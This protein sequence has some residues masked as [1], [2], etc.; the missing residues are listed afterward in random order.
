MGTASTDTKGM[1]ADVAIDSAEDRVEA[2]MRIETLLGPHALERF[3]KV[4]F[5]FADGPEALTVGQLRLLLQLEDHFDWLLR[6]DQPRLQLWRIDARRDNA[7]AFSVQIADIWQALGISLGRYVF[8]AANWAKT[9]DHETGLLPLTIAVALHCYVNEIR[10]RARGEQACDVPLQ[11]LHRLYR[12]AE[13]RNIAEKDVYPYEADVDFSITPKGQYVL[14]LLMADLSERDLPPTQRLIAQN[15]LGEWARDVV[16]DSHLAHDQHSMVVDLDSNEGIQRVT[17]RTLP[18]YRY[19]DIRAIA[20]RV[21]ETDARLANSSAEDEAVWDMPEATEADYAD[22]LAWLE[23]LYQNRSAAFQ[24]TRERKAAQPDRFARVLIGWNHIQDFIDGSRWEP[25]GSRGIFPAK[26]PGAP[27]LGAV[28][29]VL[30]RSST[31][32]P[33]F[34]A[35]QD[36]PRARHDEDN[37]ALWR[38]RDISEGGVG[39]SSDHRQDADLAVG[40]LI[41]LSMDREPNWSLGRIVRKFKG[42]EAADTRF[43][44]QILGGNAVPVR[45]TPRPADDQVK[46]TLL[47]NVTGLFL[48]RQNAAGTPDAEDLLLISSGALAYTRRY[49]LKSGN[50]RIPIRTTL[51]VQS[52]GAWAL[53]QYEDDV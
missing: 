28:G 36:V 5:G 31:D 11:A 6:N 2:I 20:R 44:I 10:W 23:K 22:T 41:L 48:T 51:P 45:L 21:E 38:I 46:N 50:K 27:A 30:A 1:L 34:D 14:M 26:H 35:S 52:A 19:L 25:K 16:L 40:S 32:L 42:L 7:L 43:G 18:S 29:E 53:I 15:W 49:E 37:F 3:R 4:C 39:L 13:E 33:V 24:A 47:S 8:G 17:E 12:I 9:P